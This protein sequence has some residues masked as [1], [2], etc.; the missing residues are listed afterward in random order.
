LFINS[1]IDR[2]PRSSSESATYYSEIKLN[3]AIICGAIADFLAAVQ[4][5]TYGAKS[6]IV[7]LAEGFCHEL[8]SKEMKTVTKSVKSK[9]NGA[10]P[11]RSELLAAHERAL[12]RV[13][14]MTARE[15]FQSLV[16][17]GI[18]T[19]DGKLTPRYGG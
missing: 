18:Y 4:T 12:K 14:G 15:R 8:V 5:L 2:F 13:K 1:S 16:R 17:A 11:T 7:R 9:T 10:V 6:E 3:S 19:Q